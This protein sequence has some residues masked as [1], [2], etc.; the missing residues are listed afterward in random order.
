MT[1]SAT[2]KRGGKRRRKKTVRLKGGA[3]HIRLFLEEDEKSPD[4]RLFALLDYLNK[5]KGA[6]KEIMSVLPGQENIKTLP[7][8][9]SD[10][11]KYKTDKSTG[12]PMPRSKT[13]I[14]GL[15]DVSQIVFPLLLRI[16][17]YLRDKYRNN[18]SSDLAERDKIHNH[19]LYTMDLLRSCNNY[20]NPWWTSQVDYYL[21]F[22][23]IK[24]TIT[25]LTDK[26]SSMSS[27]VFGPPRKNKYSGYIMKQNI[28]DGIYNGNYVGDVPNGMV[29]GSRNPPP[30]HKNYISNIDVIPVGSNASEDITR[31]VDTWLNTAYNLGKMPRIAE[32]RSGIFTSR[33]SKK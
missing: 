29:D 32:R 8:M 17:G 28:Y 22:F 14:L 20:I 1:T 2:E 13:N 16:H 11:F 19:I 3:N 5:D 12:E 18:S 7:K 25:D 23:N 4:G 15:V 31:K 9:V 6:I 30:Y 24:D 21:D 10:Y 27:S 33:V 26:V